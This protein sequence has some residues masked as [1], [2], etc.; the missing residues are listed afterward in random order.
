MNFAMVFIVLGVQ[1]I[2]EPGR[3]IYKLAHGIYVSDLFYIM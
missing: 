2:V 1:L 3:K